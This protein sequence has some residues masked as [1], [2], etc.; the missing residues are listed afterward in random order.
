MKGKFAENLTWKDIEAEFKAGTIVVVPLGAAC[1]EHGFHL[2]MNTDKILAEY[3]A[4]RLVENLPILVMPTITYHF[5]PAFLDYAGST[6]LDMTTSQTIITTL[7]D[8]WHKQGA[9]AFYILNF[10]VST[11]KP[12]K[13]AQEQLAALGIMMQFT[14][15]L[16]FDKQLVD[17]TE[18]D[19]GTHADEIET[20]MMLYIKPDVVHMENAKKDFENKPGKLSPFLNNDDPRAAYSPTGAWGDPT[21]ATPEKGKIIVERLVEYLYQDI[22][23]AEFT[24][25]H[26][27]STF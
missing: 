9:R 1:K 16:A 18:Q 27:V 8:Q 7:C 15:L 17:I 11:S 22:K 25:E 13:A 10:G 2:P 21:L 6:S 19:G 3:F 24:L 14:D 4:K 23:K 5:F 26:S 20:S 12:L